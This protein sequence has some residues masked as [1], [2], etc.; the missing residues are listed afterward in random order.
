MGCLL[1]FSP[2][3]YNN[4]FLF[5][6]LTTLKTFEENIEKG[7]VTCNIVWLVYFRIFQHFIMFERFFF[8]WTFELN[9]AFD[10]I[11]SKND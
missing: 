7:V 9:I 8:I 3:F 6:G 10:D 1:H 4:L 5:V 11:S 2:K